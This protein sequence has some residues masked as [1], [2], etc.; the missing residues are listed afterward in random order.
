MNKKIFL[1]NIAQVAVSN[2]FRLLSSILMGLILPIIFSV[3]NYGYYRLF[4]LYLTYFGLFHLGFIDGVYLHFGGKNYNELEK[5]KFV[6]YTR[7][8]LYLELAATVVIVILSLLFLDGERQLIFILLGINVI[9]ANLT[10][11]YQFISQVTSRFK[12]FSFRNIVYAILSSISVGIVF[13]LKLDNYRLFLLMILVI[14]YGLLMWY[15]FTY[16]DITFGNKNPIKNVKNDI[17]QF[18]KLGTP[19]LIANLITVLML[20]LP[21]QLV[22]W[23][24]NI[25][26]FA[27]FT[28]AYS[29]MSL[30]NIFIA[31]MSTVIYPTLKKINEARLKD[32]YNHSISLVLIVVMLAM[33]IYFPLYLFV[34]TI[35][36]KYSSSLNI[37]RIVFPGLVISSSIQIVKLNYFKVLQHIKQYFLT[38]F[39]SL[40]ISTIL[41]FLAYVLFG[42]TESIAISSVISLFI[43]YVLTELYF[44]KVYKVN[45]M[46]NLIYIMLGTLVF[47]LPY[48]I[49]NI[50]VGFTTYVVIIVI[51]TIVLYKNLFVK[52]VKNKSLE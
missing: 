19:L 1:K 8:L 48:F 47:Y 46:K 6:L 5:P 21:K 13:L 22:D 36:P 49:N 31:A 15:V 3:E 34:D 45:P 25:E 2:G 28:F 52:I 18:F 41:G 20:N 30:A 24:F 14:N 26:T 33:I 17:I 27:I 40:I 43:W 38:G 23:F 42:T 44:V 12:E 29:L 35:I 32:L 50:Y 16:R 39:A 7:F 37:L 10:T 51:L 11:Y 9:A 4:A